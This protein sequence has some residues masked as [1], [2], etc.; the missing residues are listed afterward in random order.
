MQAHGRTVLVVESFAAERERLA[1]ALEDDG[2][3]ALLCPGPSGPDFTC[4]GSRGGACPLEAEASVVV[5]DMSVASDEAMLGTPAEELLGLYLEGG[6]PVVALEAQRRPGAPGKLVSMP[7]HPETQ[8]L[9][10]AVRRLA[11]NAD[12]TRA[13]ATRF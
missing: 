2:F 10:A 9:V 5:L 1:A 12:A 7:R 13:T 4:I 3:R 8:H 11:S 6:H